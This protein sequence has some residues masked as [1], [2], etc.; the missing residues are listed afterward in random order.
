MEESLVIGR[1]VTNELGMEPLTDDELEHHDA[2]TTCEVCNKPFTEDNH[3]V[4]HHDHITGKYVGPICNLGLTYPNRKHKPKKR[5]GKRKVNKGHGKSKR[6][7][8]DEN[9]RAKYTGGHDEE[10]IEQEYEDQYSL[11]VCFHNLKS[12]DAHFVTKHFKKQ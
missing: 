11:P 1:I 5:H 3:K 6:A 4:R 9:G 8:L 7:K 10:W 12:Y 2:A